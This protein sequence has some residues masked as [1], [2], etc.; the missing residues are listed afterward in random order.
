MVKIVYIALGG[1]LGALSRYF[2][3]KF[4]NSHL[5]FGYIPFGTV[6]VNVVGAFLLSFLMFLSIER[7]E[8]SRSFL[9]FFGTGFLGSFTTFS[10][11][12]YESLSLFLT[13]PFRAFCYFSSNVVLGF[14][15]AFLGMVLGR[16]RVL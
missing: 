16:G 9:A 15:A 6:I 4:V 8:I 2:V 5:P 7:L 14:L 11:F 13:S 12:T 1:A 10:T 3:S